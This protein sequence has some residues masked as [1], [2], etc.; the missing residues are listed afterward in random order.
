[1]RTWNYTYKTTDGLHHEDTMEAPRKDDVYSALRR[2]GIHPIKVEERIAPV[3]K[4]GLRGMRKRDWVIV[5]IAVAVVLVVAVLLSFRQGTKS[6]QAK[7][8]GRTSLMANDHSLQNLS[9]EASEILDGYYSASAEIDYALLSN[10]ALLEKSEDL[11]DFHA[12]ITKAKAAVEAAREKAGSLFRARYKEIPE[13]REEAQREAQRLYGV[14]MGQLDDAEEQVLAREASIALLEENRGKWRVVKGNVVWADKSLEQAFL[15]RLPENFAI[16][17][18]WIK[19]FGVNGIDK[20]GE[21]G[22]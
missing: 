6:E 21:T 1:M 10:Y 3:V 4:K 8:F 15:M 5:G 2:K 9:R 16:T 18:R 12:E 7:Q 13:D 14:L 11:S 19:D 17:S 22:D 20:D